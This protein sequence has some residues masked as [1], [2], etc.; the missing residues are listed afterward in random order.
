M[1][2]TSDAQN[3]RPKPSLLTSGP[4][5]QKTR[6]TSDAPTPATVSHG[7]KYLRFSD[8]IS[9]HADKLG[10]LFTEGMEKEGHVFTRKSPLHNYTGDDF[11]KCAFVILPQ[12]QYKE[13][14]KLNK[15]T[16]NQCQ[17]RFW[18]DGIRKY[19][20]SRNPLDEEKD[21][22]DRRNLSS[23]SAKIQEQLTLVEAEMSSNEKEVR[24]LQ[25]K[26][27]R[28]GQIIN[29]QNAYNDKFLSA[30]TE[31]L[32]VDP[33]NVQ[34]TLT[35]KM[36]KN[37]WFMIL[38]RYRF[39]ADGEPVRIGDKVYLKSVKFGYL[40]SGYWMYHRHP[41]YSFDYFDATLSSKPME[42]TVGIYRRNNEMDSSRVN[43][44]SFVRFYNHESES[45]LAIK[46]VTTETEK[47][48]E[49]KVVHSDEEVQMRL[50]SA[51]TKKYLKVA[52]DTLNLSLVASPVVGN[53]ESRDA[54]TNSNP[55]SGGASRTSTVKID[56]V[57]NKEKHL[58][59]SLSVPA[60]GLGVV[61]GI[62]SGNGGILRRKSSVTF[63]PNTDPTLFALFPVGEDKSLH[64]RSSF[65]V[66]H[67]ASR[68][69]LHVASASSKDSNWNGTGGA[70]VGS[71][72]VGGQMDSIL[73]DE[74]G[75]GMLDA[76]EEEEYD[77]LLTSFA[78]PR[79]LAT[80]R[81]MSRRL[82]TFG[83]IPVKTGIF[84]AKDFQQ[85][86]FSNA[87]TISIVDRKVSTLLRYTSTFVPFFRHFTQKCRDSGKRDDPT[88]LLSPTNPSANLLLSSAPPSPLTPDFIVTAPLVISRI[89][90]MMLRKHIRD[91]IYFCVDSSNL[92][93]LTREVFLKGDSRENEWFVY[94]HFS[95]LQNHIEVIPDI[96][97]SE[98]L[99]E[100]VQGSQPVVEKIGESGPELIDGFI[101]LMFRTDTSTTDPTV[102][103]T[104]D[105]NLLGFLVNLCYCK[106]KPYPRVQ[107]YVVDR[108]L[109]HH[110]H[111][112]VVFRTR[113]SSP[114][115]NSTTKFEPQVEIQI[116]PK[117]HV[118][119]PLHEFFARELA[120]E[121]QKKKGLQRPGGRRK[122]ADP[123]AA[124]ALSA[125]SKAFYFEVLLDLYEV[126]CRGGNMGCVAAL[127]EE[128]GLVDPETT[129]K[130]REDDCNDL[131][132]RP[133]GNA[134]ANVTALTCESPR[135]SDLIMMYDDIE[136][137]NTNTALEAD[138]LPEPQPLKPKSQISPTARSS[139]LY[140]TMELLAE[141]GRKLP[142]ALKLKEWFCG[143]LEDIETQDLD[144]ERNAFI[145]ATLKL[146]KALIDYGFYQ[147]DA[148]L[149]KMLPHLIEV[150]DASNDTSGAW[151]KH[152]HLGKTDK[153]RGHPMLHPPKT[154]NTSALVQ[155]LAN[156]NWTELSSKLDQILLELA[157]FDDPTLRRA[158][159]RLL[160]RTYSNFFEL[161]KH[162]RAALI[163]TGAESE[164][165]L[166]TVA[167]A[168][169]TLL[170]SSF[171]IGGLAAGISKGSVDPSGN[172]MKTVEDM[173]FV[174]EDLA[175]LCTSAS[176]VVDTPQAA[177]S[178]RT[179]LP[180]RI[181]QR[182]L[183][184]Y[185][186]E[187]MVL[188]LLE[189]TNVSGK[190]IRGEDLMPRS[191]TETTTFE[192]GKKMK[193]LFKNFI[194]AGT[195]FLRA[196]CQGNEEHK[197]TILSS[198]PSI[199]HTLFVVP[200][201]AV[202][203]FVEIFDTPD[204][205]LRINSEHVAQI[206]DLLVDK[207]KLYHPAKS[208]SIDEDEIRINDSKKMRLY[209]QLLKTLASVNGTPIKRNQLVIV[210]QLS[211]RDMLD[212]T[213]LLRL[214]PK[215]T[216]LRPN[217]PNALKKLF[218]ENGKHNRCYL[219]FLAHILDLLATCCD[220]NVKSIESMCQSVLDISLMVA[221]LCGTVEGGGGGDAI[222]LSL[223]RAYLRLITSAWLDVAD[224]DQGVRFADTDDAWNIV[225]A[226]ELFLISLPK[227]QSPNNRS[228]QNVLSWDHMT[229]E[230]ANYILEGIIPFLTGFYDACSHQGPNTTARTPRTALSYSLNSVLL[231]MLGGSVSQGAHRERQKKILECL[232]SL[233]FSQYSLEV[234]DEER[235]RVSDL[236]AILLDEDAS[237]HTA[238]TSIKE[239]HPTHSESLPLRQKQ[240]Y[241]DPRESE[242]NESFQTFATSAFNESLAAQD[243]ADLL[244]KF[245]FE[246]DEDSITDADT[247]LRSPI[248]MLIQHL[249]ESRAM[250]SSATLEAGDD[251]QQQQQE[252]PQR[253]GGEVL[254]TGT[255]LEAGAADDDDSIEF[256][257][258]SFAVLCGLI[259]R[260]VDKI[261]RCKKE[262]EGSQRQNDDLA[263]VLMVLN[264]E[265]IQ[266][267]NALDARNATVLALKYCDN[268]TKEYFY[269]G[270]KLLQNLLID[271]NKN[272]QDHMLSYFL[273]TR[274][275]AFFYQIYNRMRSKIESVGEMKTFMAHHISGT[276]SASGKDLPQLIQDDIR[277]AKTMLHVLQLMCE[278]HNNAIQNYMRMQPDNLKS[279]NLVALVVE[280]LRTLVSCQQRFGGRTGL[281]RGPGGESVLPSVASGEAPG[282]AL[283]WTSI[284]E[285]QVQALNVLV[286][287]MQG[288]EENQVEV[289]NARIAQTVMAILADA[290]DI[291]LP[292]GL[293]DSGDKLEGSATLCLSTLTS[294][295]GP[296]SQKIAKELTQVVDFR[297]LMS[298][299]IRDYER[300]EEEREP[301]AEYLTS[302]F[303]TFI[304]LAALKPHM[305][306]KQVFEFFGTPAFQFFERWT[307]R[308]EVLQDTQSDEKNLAHLYFR[309]P[310]ECFKLSSKVRS[311]LVQ[312][313][314]IFL[315]ITNSICEPTPGIRT[316]TDDSELVVLSG[317]GHDRASC[318]W[319]SPVAYAFGAVHLALWSTP[320]PDFL[321]SVTKKS[322][323]NAKEM[324]F[325]GK[326][327]GRN[328]TLFLT[329]RTRKR[330][331]QGI[332]R[333]FCKSNVESW[334]HL[335]IWGV[336][337]VGLVRFPIIWG[338]LLL[339]VVYRVDLIRAI[340]MAFY[341][342]GSELLSMGWLAM[343]I[344]FIYASL[345]AV[346]IGSLFNQS[347][348]GFL[349][350]CFFTI[351]TT[352]ITDGFSSAL[353][354][355]GEATSFQQNWV[356]ALNITFFIVEIAVVMNAVAGLIIDAFGEQRSKREA[357]R[358]EMLNHCFICSLPATQFQRYAQGFKHHILH[359]HNLWSYL[360]FLIHL[361]KKAKTEYT[362]LESYVSEKLERKDLS[363]FPINRAICLDKQNPTTEESSSED[364]KRDHLAQ[365]ARK[366]EELENRLSMLMNVEIREPEVGGGK[367][368]G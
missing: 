149:K 219:E 334:Y 194:A 312:E 65:R 313:I 88:R 303:D 310:V 152:H 2:D 276:H 187:Q 339:D 271:G 282:S 292:E 342:R 249:F 28:Y 252:E 98:T 240:Y 32:R 362:A 191:E 188:R 1:E 101:R 306:S 19:R 294:G 58:E 259:R 302:S 222:P 170:S 54:P 100:L 198:T 147:D 91:L 49:Q 183:K 338:L 82:S 6:S 217:T 361:R 328:V 37:A 213:D 180:N 40:Y 128:L 140:T 77:E 167:K 7:D 325:D 195:E 57:D 138:N 227:D 326:E 358:E 146:L 21:E 97:A 14:K 234:S 196:F 290:S 364:A 348:C 206:V 329:R 263:G 207:G 13:C 233:Q 210:H 248:R 106:D 203:L 296:D 223:K 42:W 86:D 41:I 9:L 317:F 20:I 116:N 268:N 333:M 278:G 158:S 46:P 185:H 291:D 179:R 75:D 254:S 365:M 204:A 327:G 251:E 270:L 153:N 89:D 151:S 38:P 266:V 45:Y 301:G 164:R 229:E 125:K 36:S 150:L 189:M 10:F 115:P 26:P 156:T 258:K 307:A 99:M 316:D 293:R 51:L 283:F 182:I 200:E 59:D 113:L 174:L 117:S 340:A 110:V 281:L 208:D 122:S 55:I 71:R 201:A 215:P 311:N 166:S 285:L 131:C 322:S 349:Y 79:M 275:E 186:L 22:S 220:G 319:F 284:T 136:Y 124:Y 224:D 277:E 262:G 309:I 139:F 245:A 351:L 255:T 232:I 84:F 356:A 118:W 287:F 314:A 343:V 137:N 90:G 43:A 353:P 211:K 67:L 64:V 272:V 297:I 241:E 29:L 242:L 120:L 78:A 323:A 221:Q 243:F 352:A 280:Y 23:I 47:A 52:P 92:D 142:I 104:Y 320:S 335:I 253:T 169:S 231:Q 214:T 205:C 367:R 48:D 5:I 345:S 141:M 197:E 257:K 27:V 173:V 305:T 247:D 239:N 12:Q 265:R 144:M 177:G 337:L 363:W 157:K 94:R 24:R 321:S 295:S 298:G 69:W 119:I 237:P 344:A 145:S 350:Q 123:R 160:H 286:E 238:A 181:N 324:H 318:A 61:G 269:A 105:G 56:V 87:F 163:L 346:V 246:L 3:S 95:L 81:R 336:S 288:C 161:E 132:G 121:N 134:E 126:V 135:P 256:D 127:T 175:R 332:C 107:S 33:N 212:F 216:K 331:L 226:L 354:N 235:R 192:E 83:S 250:I 273:S 184:N 111:D 199:V 360:F 66:M 30:S 209:T 50:H 133:I 300:F 96:G 289:H 244:D 34:L 341:S 315:N 25:G 357:A 172:D 73:E 114:P 159:F 264:R 202:P 368:A 112:G 190:D 330:N 53:V 68:S 44:G 80:S 129:G 108:L 359:D 154:P 60:M 4:P 85:L 143:H 74:D 228:S 130:V 171:L 8:N 274:D 17:Y 193:E 260:T 72:S 279:F 18:E 178:T 63:A 102:H 176:S 304:F 35:W 155:I 148:S 261:K 299:L 16:N 162:T 366:F 76:E 31:A 347:T 11:L 62:S 109:R 165:V 308:I 39:R 168:A 218:L 236:R 267:Q 225:S 70:G 15:L 103:C 230:V 93:P 355:S